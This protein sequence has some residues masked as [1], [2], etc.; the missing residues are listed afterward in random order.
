M[1]LR[2]KIILSNLATIII[3]IVLILL[4][5]TGYI[6]FGDVSSLKQINRAPG[7]EDRLTEAMNI[8][9]TFEAEMSD[10]DWE[11]VALSGEQGTDII[12]SPQK[13]RIGELESLG[14]HVQVE[15]A[16]GI[17]F[18][19]MDD[20]D[21]EILSKTG[22]GTDGAMIWSGD[23]LIIQDRFR[24]SGQDHF[25]T[26]V[27]NEGRSDRG[28]A[29]SLLPVYMVS[30][31][32]FAIFLVIAVVCIISTS[33]IA[34]RWIS[35]SV[36]EP[37][38]QLK[39]GADRIAG[40]NLDDCISY[41]GQDEFGDVCKEFDYMRL[42]L[43]E[44]REEQKR[45]EEDR[46]ELLR[47]IS[48]DL[49]SPLTSIKGYAYGL[50]DGIADTEEKRQRYCEA[51][52]TRMDDLERLMGS[53]SHLVR[54]EDEKS[55]LKLEKVCLDEY[56][57]QMLSEKSAWFAEQKVFVDYHAEDKDAEVMIDIHE[58]Q[59]VFVNLFENTVR[60][61]VR[62][63]SHIELSVL[64]REQE[65]EIHFTDD[66]PGVDQKHLKHLFDS[67][68]RAD[69][70]RTNPEMGS[71]LGLAVVKRIIEGEN[72]RV[73]AVSGTQQGSQRHGDDRKANQGLGIIMILPLFK[74][75]GHEE[76]TDYRRRSA[77]G[78]SG[79]GLS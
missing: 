76:D 5:W 48:H 52:L 74:E 44:A 40:G 30:P 12:A 75:A 20:T 16:D 57:R 15:T 38:D 69:E 58:M 34:T 23:S 22:T 59:R 43:K 35:R 27:Y 2:K 17:A 7:R 67:F 77:G 49:R 71:G 4:I 72:G 45:Y 1:S 19:N 10:M 53:L 50:K 24:L 14:Y 65:A 18:C 11:K 73:F 3:P 54:L 31:A 63:P 64:I 41:E 51:I 70:S 6:Y 33:L 39:T 68:Y 78:R 13:E 8:L 9:Y 62:E 25:L 32:V 29:A 42:Q 36:L 47:G 60:Y 26:V 56:I 28:M 79:E 66:G 55:I 46:R 37:L 61:R 21:R